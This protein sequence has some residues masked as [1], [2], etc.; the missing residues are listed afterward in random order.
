MIN[1]R[2]MRFLSWRM[3]PGQIILSK[4]VAAS[5]LKRRLG[6]P[7]LSW[8]S[9]KKCSARTE[10]SSRRSSRLGTAIGTTLRRWNNSSRNAPR[11]ISCVKSFAVAE[12]TRISTFCA[13]VP[14]TRVKLWSTKTRKSRACT[15]SGKSAISSK[16]KI[17]LCADSNRPTWCSLP[18]SST[19]NSFASAVSASREAQ[20]TTTSGVLNLLELMWI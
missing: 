19:P 13:A 16:N 7:S 8:N 2:S 9:P 6:R 5:S 20:L 4:V 11:S 3:F 14:S 12:I 10:M 18:L 1:T 15:T 17:P